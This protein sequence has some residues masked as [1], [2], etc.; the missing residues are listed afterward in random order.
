MARQSEGEAMNAVKISRAG[1]NAILLEMRT[2]NAKKTEKLLLL[3][4]QQGQKKNGIYATKGR[5]S[6]YDWHA[7]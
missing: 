2:K 3:M 1:R 5:R 4:P 7:P 6:G